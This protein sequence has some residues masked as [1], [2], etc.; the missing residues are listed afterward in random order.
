MTQGETGR[1]IGG[2]LWKEIVEELR[3]ADIE[4][5]MRNLG[6]TI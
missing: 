4:G 5:I 3:F 2:R 1:T 6:T